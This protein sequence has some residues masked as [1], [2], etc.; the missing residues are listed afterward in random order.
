VESAIRKRYEIEMV[1]FQVAHDWRRFESQE[2]SRGFEEAKML[3][4]SQKEERWRTFVEA[5]R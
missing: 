2:T 5:E 1:G 3:N 4:T